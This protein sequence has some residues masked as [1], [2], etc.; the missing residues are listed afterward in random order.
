MRELIQEAIHF[1]K[2]LNPNDM[3]NPNEIAPDRVKALEARYDE[4]LEIARAEYE[5]EPPT[6]YN[7]DGYNLYKRLAEYKENHLLFLYDRRVPYS[8]SLSERL[9]RKLKRKQHQVMT[10]R[11]F[12]GLS[13]LCDSL[14]VIETLRSREENLYRNTSDIFNRQYERAD[15]LT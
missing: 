5:Y 2:H 4:I 7:K 15:K 14:G 10:F 1:R 12:S 8:N 6:K 9:L 13:Y 3:R 11:S